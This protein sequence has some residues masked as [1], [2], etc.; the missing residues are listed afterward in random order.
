MK[1]VDFYLIENQVSNAKFKLASRL[2][3]KLQRQDSRALVVTDDESSAKLLDET[4]WTYSD[5][6]FLAHDDLRDKQAASKVHIGPHNTVSQA[7]LERD[8]DVLINLTSEI[9]VY[10]HHFLRVAEIV[11]SDGNSKA[12]GR[13]RYKIYKTE[14]FELKMHNLS[15]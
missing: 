12:A 5:A 7:V 2:A 11:E 9:P 10:S 14:G 13:A 15:L 1:Q 6:S 8:Y 3:N 4:M